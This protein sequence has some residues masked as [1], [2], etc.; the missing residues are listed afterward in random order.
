MTLLLPIWQ[1]DVLSIFHALELR[2]AL[3]LEITI[4]N[5]M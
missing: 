2:K 3:M 4:Q 5:E 1:C